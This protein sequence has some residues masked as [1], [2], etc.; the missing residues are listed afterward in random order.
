MSCCSAAAQRSTVVSAA[1]SVTHRSVPTQPYDSCHFHHVMIGPGARDLIG[2]CSG[3]GEEHGDSQ[4]QGHRAAR[5]LARHH[6]FRYSAGVS[7]GIGLVDHPLDLEERNDS[8]PRRLRREIQ[9]LERV[10]SK[11]DPFGEPFTADPQVTTALTAIDASN[12]SILRVLVFPTRTSRQGFELCAQT[13]GDTKL[14]FVQ[15]T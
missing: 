14:H 4:V 13:G 10:Y 5:A 1:R 6:H 9:N 12:A 8:D 2:R 15:V 3:T 11:Y 7:G